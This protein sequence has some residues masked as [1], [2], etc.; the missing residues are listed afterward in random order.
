MIISFTQTVAKPWGHEE[1]IVRTNQYALKRLHINAHMR[2]SLQYHKFKAE[3]MTIIKGKCK[4][5]IYGENDDEF[6][7]ERD[8]SYGIKPFTIHRN[9]AVTDCVILEVSTPELSDVVR[10]ED[11]YGRKT[12][13]KE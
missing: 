8:A 6:N 13:E 12:S 7:M 11:D 4:L 9:I 2:T 10:L 1:L 5:I 3:S